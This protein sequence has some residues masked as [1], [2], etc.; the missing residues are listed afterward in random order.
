M[1]AAPFARAQEI[2]NGAMIGRAL[3]GDPNLN[4]FVYAP[5]SG[6]EGKP[7]FITVHGLSRNVTEHAGLFAPLA[8]KYDVVMIA[9][10]F[11]EERFDDYQRLGRE[12]R[13]ERA[14]LALN[15]IVA[16]V[17]ELT[18]AD[19]EK[20][21]LFGYSGGGQFAHRYLFAHPERVAKAA[22]GAAGWYTMPDPEVEY[23]YG[24]KSAGLLEGVSFDPERFLRVPVCVFVGTED[25]LRGENL[26]QNEQADRQGRNRLER[27]QTWVE[28]MRAAA[29][30]HGYDTPYT[31]STQ[32]GA[33]HSFDENM[34]A[35]MGEGVMEC[36]FGEGGG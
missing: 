17:G 35:G 33:D 26:R 1:L 13:G 24:I 4:Y 18:G 14:D 15:K 31:F 34:E 25:V 2:P 6:G 30:E 28:A 7:I 32:E 5:R 19:A 8:E 22:V 3:E 16:E 36:F 27:G 21:Y 11:P 10:F 23:P 12:G 29:A 20:V 9:P